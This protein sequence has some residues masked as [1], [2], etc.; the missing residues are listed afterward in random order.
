MSQRVFVTGGSG[1]VGQAVIEELLSRN[2]D[3]IALVN[4]GSLG[5]HADR[6]KTIRGDLFNASAL[7][8]GMSDCDAVIHLVG[9]IMEKPSAGVTF[10]RIHVDGT[11][12]V[13][14][15]AR[16]AGVRRYVHMSSLGTRP[17]AASTYNQTKYAAEEL[18]RASGLDWTIFRPSMIHGP[19]GDFTRMQVAWAKRQAMPFLFMPYFG[20]GVLGM[21]GAGRIQP[22]YVNDVARAFVDAINNPKT[23]G[24]T[25][26]LAGPDVLTWP[27][28]HRSV[29][30]AVTGKSRWVMPLPAWYAKAL[31]RV[32]P[33]PLL[34]FNRDQIVMS[35]ED[36]P[37]D[38]AKFAAD[39]GWTPRPFAET[40]GAYAG[41]F[42]GA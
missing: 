3:V 34:P 27:E 9:I 14:D 17:N 29:A 25:Y 6:V 7:E 11:R 8:S 13:L 38:V 33:A 37:A 10:H 31:T 19:R 32:V 5:A 16:T 23:I 21:G 39:F 36:N 30:R 4:R 2:I 18:V 26:D 35:Q 24:Q 20:R 42:S 1:F 28:L 41:D 12:A 22:V 40:L 15:A